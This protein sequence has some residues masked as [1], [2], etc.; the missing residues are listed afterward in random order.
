[1]QN[2][3]FNDKLRLAARALATG[4]LPELII[5]Y[6]AISKALAGKKSMEAPASYIRTIMNRVS[7]VRE[8]GSVK[9]KKGECKNPEHDY[10]GMD[11]FTITICT[12]DRKTIYD[13]KDVERIKK[14]T[15]RKVAEKMLTLSPNLANYAPEEYATLAKAVAEFHEIIKANFLKEE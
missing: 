6:S 8:V 12:S 14:A 9:V 13:K 10:F 3:S 7:E 2:Q 1:M 15:A 5:P 4:E 11:V